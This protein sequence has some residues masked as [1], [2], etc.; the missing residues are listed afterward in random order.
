MTGV[1]KATV[2]REKLRGTA[3]QNMQTAIMNSDLG[4]VDRTTNDWLAAISGDPL[5]DSV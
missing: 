1:Q 5:A 2:N 4:N 3:V